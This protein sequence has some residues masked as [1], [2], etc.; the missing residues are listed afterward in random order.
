MPASEAVEATSVQ[1]DPAQV[2]AVECCEAANTTLFGYD[3]HRSGFGS[4]TSSPVKSCRS[5]GMLE[6]TEM[7][8]LP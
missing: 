8:Q 3:L 2:D 1:S 5:T 7:S 4:G 6:T